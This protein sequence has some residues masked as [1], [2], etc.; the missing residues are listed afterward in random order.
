M[1]NKIWSGWVWFSDE[2]DT[3]R[4]Q[5]I[6]EEL[7]TI[8]DECDKYGI[9]FVKISDET[10]V[11]ELGIPVPSLVYFENR[12]PHLYEGDLADEDA[13]LSWLIHQLKSDE[14]EE[15]TDEMLDQLIERHPYVT[16][17]F[18]KLCCLI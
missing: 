13:T 1:C 6:I 3:H 5:K 7:E 14:I 16:A 18:C 4:S 17:L 11:R 9:I 10:K 12:I 2:K 15:V 8:D